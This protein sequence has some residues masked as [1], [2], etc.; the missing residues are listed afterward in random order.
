MHPQSERIQQAIQ[1]KLKTLNAATALD[2]WQ[3]CLIPAGQAAPAG[4]QSPTFDDRAWETIRL[5]RTWSSLDGEAWFRTAPAL[6]AAVE[7]I[8]L[9]GSAVEMNFMMVIGGTVY[10]NGEARYTEPSWC[11]TRAVPLPLLDHYIPGTPLS[12][13]VQGNAGD[14]FGLFLHAS[15]HFSRLAEAINALDIVRSQWLFCAYLLEQPGHAGQ[16]HLLEAAAAALNLDALAANDWATW[17][18]SVEAGRAV[19]APLAAAAKQY[20]AHLVAHSHIDMNWLWPMAETDAVCRRDFRAMDGLMT[21]FPEFRFSQSQAATYSMVEKSDPALFAAIRQRVAAGQWDVTA[22]TWVEGDLNTA[23]GEAIARHFLHTRRYIGER[24]GV[25][26]VICWEPDTFGHPATMPQILA[27]A[28]IRFYYFCRAGKRHPLF[29]W[30]GPDGSR[31][32][33]V[34]DLRGYG[35]V[36]MPSD[37]V[38][39]VLD[40]GQANGLQ[41]SLYVYGVGDHGGAATARDV[42][43]A[44]TITVT[45]LLPRALPSSTVDFYQKALAEAPADL[46]V[47]RSE[48]N[49]VFEGCYTSH[50]D[51]KRY[52]RDCENRLLSAET[53]AAIAALYTASAAPNDGLAESW[54]TLCFHQFH[55][56]LCGCAIG[57]T[58]NEAQ[59]RLDAV[60]AT[61]D[62]TADAALQALAGSGTAESLAVVVF[63]PLAWERDDVVAVPLSAFAGRVPAALVDNTGRV[64]PVQVNPGGA[65][66]PELVFVAQQVPALGTLIYRPTAAPEGWTA[67]PAADAETL[68]MENGLL[69]V[70]VHPASGAIDQLIDIAASRDLA[71]P[72][73]GWGPEAKVNAG[74]LNRLQIAWEQPHGMSA[75]NIGDITRTENLITGAEVRL[76]EVGPVYT[77]IEVR[78]R[79]LH[80]SLVQRIVLYRG[81]WRIDCET[82]I[83]WHERGNAHDDA[84]LLAVTFTPYLGR[85]EA[86]FEVPFGSVQRAADG[87][88]SPALRWADLS[89][90]DPLIPL[91]GTGPARAM[92]L[93]LLNNCKYGHRAQ[94]NTLGLTLVRAS[95]EP[96]VN[97]DE[98][99]HRLTYSLYP[100]T[101]G[102]REAGTVRQAGQLNQPLQAAV[103]PVPTVPAAWTGKAALDCDAPNVL[104]TA[105]KLA[106]DQPVQGRALVIRLV[107]MHGKPVDAHLTVAW[108]IRQ[109]TEVDLVERPVADVAASPDGLHVAFKP[110]EIRTL[111]LIL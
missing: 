71:G 75:W 79:F 12:L 74:M 30:E 98:G 41:R 28:G 89:E 47:V 4:I 52:N 81:L 108:P 63:N 83:D 64:L 72:W 109:A 27:K 43:M 33:A 32:L 16:A 92:G 80:S 73:G 24:F 91:A 66:G 48:L 7:G 82:E 105:V 86:T 56:I 10:V 57:V 93:T 90:V 23:A 38:G 44:R 14:G 67:A 50:G 36:V 19:L 102:W 99:A 103:L 94:G 107:E 61:A 51:I 101:A 34:Q 39:S 53:A 21:R 37:I 18:A 40:F 111:K 20:T 22:S 13:A 76:A 8:D 87:R 42:E 2:T 77:A 15:L 1:A 85:T 25:E 104:V 54:R 31:V 96:D 49:T 6:P 110:Y 95:Y 88:E 59:E 58:Y 26:P 45:P 46:P 106:E 97:P 3:F 17:W 55:D 11:D 5:M 60:L 62:R 100:H 84:P 9:T 68:T 78:R 29:W 69:R 70:H 65:D 35:G